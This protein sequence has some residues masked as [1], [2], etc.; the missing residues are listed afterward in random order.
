MIVV[1]II[2]I[3][4]IIMSIVIM[5]IIIIIMKKI[6]MKHLKSSTSIISC[7][8]CSG[9]RLRTDQIVRMSGDLG[10][11]ITIVR[12]LKMKMIIWLMKIVF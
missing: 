7:M 2:I 3:I 4:I 12:I 11:F 5:I 6:T 10:S 9:E 1:I 8:R